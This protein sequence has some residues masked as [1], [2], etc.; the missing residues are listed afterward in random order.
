M[1]LLATL[2][3]I[4]I[5]VW[6]AFRYSWQDHA[7]FLEVDPDERAGR[8][9]ELRGGNFGK[10]YP[11]WL[12]RGL[13]LLNHRFGKPFSPTALNVC[14]LVA[15]AYSYIFFFL[16]YVAGA[17]GGLHE[18]MAWLPPVK[19]TPIVVRL[20]VAAF[21]ILLPPLGLVVAW[22]IGRFPVRWER[23]LKLSMRRRYSTKKRW[24]EFGYRAFSALLIG[25]LVLWLGASSRGMHIFAALFG[26]GGY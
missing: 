6:L 9:V 26:L 8:I 2:L 3:G 25:G 11:A 15:L 23:R 1:T 19:E 4:T 24:F 17:P 5:S 12:K 16:A 14:V 21:G 13:D 7:K 18:N 22:Q 20:L 10:L